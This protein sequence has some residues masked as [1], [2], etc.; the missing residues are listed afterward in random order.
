[1]LLLTEVQYCQKM[2][3]N[4]IYCMAYDSQLATIIQ[5]TVQANGD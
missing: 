4:G 5:R 1:M 3:V 2:I